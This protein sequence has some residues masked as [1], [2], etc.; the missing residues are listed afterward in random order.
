[1]SNQKKDS[2]KSSKK[3]TPSFLKEDTQQKL[4]D[5]ANNFG[6]TPDAL[7]NTLINDEIERNRLLKISDEIAQEKTNETT[8]PSQKIAKIC[9]QHLSVLNH[10]SESADI[11]SAVENLHR[12]LLRQNLLFV[13]AREGSIVASKRLETKRLDYYWFAGSLSKHT[14]MWFGAADVYLFHEMLSPESEGL[15]VGMPTNVEVCFQVFTHLY[16]LLK[17]VKVA[18]KKE[19]GNW[20]KKNEVE[21]DANRYMSNFVEELQHTQAFIENEDYSKPVYDYVVEHYSYT[22]R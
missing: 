17:T 9:K 21:N 8:V 4:I 11:R 19:A 1:M 3:D 15:F 12:D 13:N 22:L 10:D 5:C 20:G 16:Q 7:L 14:A 6:I 18:Y 2:G